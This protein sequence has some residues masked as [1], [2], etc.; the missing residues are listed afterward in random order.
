MKKTIFVTIL[1]SG[2]IASFSVLAHGATE[3]EVTKGRAIF[4]K[5][6]N[7]ELSCDGLLDQDFELVGEYFM[8][9]MMGESHEAMNTMME[10]MMGE[11]GEKDVHIAMGKRMSGCDPTAI[12]PQGMMNMM[13]YGTGSGMMGNGMMGNWGNN[14]MG[15]WNNMMGGNFFGWNW[16]GLIYQVLF[17]ALVVL[18]IAALIKWLSKQNNK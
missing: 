6:E 10:N 3:E 4:E 1:I 15:G 12:M 7:K 2:I 13:N 8:A 11:K 18:A 9:K 16:L 17:I 14:M 5:L